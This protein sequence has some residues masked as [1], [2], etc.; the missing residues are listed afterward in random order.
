MVRINDEGQIVEH[1]GVVDTIG[2]MGQVG[3]LPR[4]E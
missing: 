2:T 3:L 4:P 1:W